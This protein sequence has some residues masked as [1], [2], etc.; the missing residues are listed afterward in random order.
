[1]IVFSLAETVFTPFVSTAFAQISDHRPVVEAFNLMQ[2][3]MSVGESLGAFAGGALFSL[4]LAERAQPVYWLG[5][6]GAALAVVVGYRLTGPRRQP[7]PAAARE[8]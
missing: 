5:L 1:M 6:W 8:L 4:A 2:I 3:V 7:V